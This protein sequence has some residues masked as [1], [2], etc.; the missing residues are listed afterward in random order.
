MHTVQDWN[1]ETEMRT[2]QK[3]SNLVRWQ[4]IPVRGYNASDG[5][6]RRNSNVR[7]WILLQRLQCIA[8]P[9]NRDFGTNRRSV[10]QREDELQHSRSIDSNFAIGS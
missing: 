4:H 1:N 5:F 2:I 10:S 3:V 6:R 7:V 8:T 9:M